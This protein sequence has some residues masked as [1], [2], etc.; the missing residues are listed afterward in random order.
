MTGESFC[1]IPWHR[2]CEMSDQKPIDWQL[3]DFW[4]EHGDRRGVP[5]G[6]RHLLNAAFTKVPVSAFPELPHGKGHPQNSLKTA[7]IENFHYN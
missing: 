2:Y 7:E 5:K 3:Q 4:E 1:K 6:V